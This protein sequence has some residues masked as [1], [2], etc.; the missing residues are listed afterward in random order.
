M[1]DPIKESTAEAI[2][3]LHAEGL[4]IAMLTGDSRTTAQA[5]ARKLGIDEVVAE[6]LPEQKK[7]A[8]EKLQAAG[9]R[10]RHGG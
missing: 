5:V 10:R 2:E 1:A 6:V 7:D 4:R 8:V 9:P 3:A